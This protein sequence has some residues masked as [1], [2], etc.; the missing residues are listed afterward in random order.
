MGVHQFNLVFILAEQVCC[1]PPL[2]KDQGKGY[3]RVGQCGT[4]AYYPS[5]EVW[6]FLDVGDIM[7]VKKVG[8]AVGKWI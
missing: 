7:W 4:V 3:L 6:S 5:R 8:P 1:F 2:I